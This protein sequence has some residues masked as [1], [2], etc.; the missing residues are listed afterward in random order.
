MVPD[1]RETKV[2]RSTKPM[3]ETP[4]SPKVTTRAKPRAAIPTTAP[5]A[6]HI[7]RAKIAR[8][9]ADEAAPAPAT[10]RKAAV[11]PASPALATRVPP[12][13][14]GE[15]RAQIEKLEAANTIL[16]AEG[17]EGTRT[18]KAAAHRIA[19]LEGQ[20]AQLQDEAA[21]AV[22][23]A[24]ATEK[25]EA[26][27][28]ALKAKGRETSRA[29][30]LAQGRI[31]ELEGQVEQL[32]A[33]AVKPVMPSPAEAEVKA[34]RRGRSPVRKK[35]VDPADAVPPGVAVEEPEPMDPEAEAARN[36]LEENLSAAQ[37]QEEE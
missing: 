11:V 25:L 17:R 19:E 29:A 28:A 31:A 21:R 8:A 12:P 22:D 30:N 14:K 5:A 33:Q 37:G 18:A 36:A 16:K 24:A 9:F 32:Q 34:S 35:A 6:A 13:S 20:V 7:P 15:L 1:K 4:R 2:A 27:N 23:P 3:T 26:A 10:G